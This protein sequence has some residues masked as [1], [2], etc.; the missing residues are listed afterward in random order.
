MQ[1]YLQTQAVASGER[2]M[3]EVTM[4]QH[5]APLI[6]SSCCQL[7]DFATLDYSSVRFS[8]STLAAA[9]LY[10]Y[11]GSTCKVD[12]LTGY[13]VEDLRPCLRW[14]SYFAIVLERHHSA[15]STCSSSDGAD[16]LIIQTHDTPYAL[17]DKVHQ[18]RLRGAYGRRA[19][20]IP[21]TPEPKNLGEGSIVG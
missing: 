9:A 16:G 15:R 10:I 17:L 18:L 19:S 3:I 2:K 13:T 21:L 8:P 12:E 6:F 1:M 11:A 5:Y 14:M 7:I 20:S 4:T